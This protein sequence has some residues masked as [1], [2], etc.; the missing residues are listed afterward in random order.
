MMGPS[1]GIKPMLSNG[2]FDELLHAS[3]LLGSLQLP[4]GRTDFVVRL[5]HAA[6][7]SRFM[8][9]QGPTTKDLKEKALISYGVLGHLQ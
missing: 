9:Q 6:G 3:C 1:P 8:L 5:I 4:K 7:R 2:K